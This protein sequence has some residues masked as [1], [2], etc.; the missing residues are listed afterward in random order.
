MITDRPAALFLARGSEYVHGKESIDFQR[1]YLEFILRFIGVTDMQTFVIEPTLAAGP[2]V[3][4][5]KINTVQHD[6]VEYAKKF[7]RKIC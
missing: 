6:A 1:P 4:Q 5:T 2:N 3:A 7:L